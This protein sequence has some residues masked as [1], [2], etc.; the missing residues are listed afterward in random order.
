M[1]KVDSRN[2]AIGDEQNMLYVKNALARRIS[3]FKRPE[4]RAKLAK[5]SIVCKNFSEQTVRAC[6]GERKT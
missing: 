3:I 1:E 2:T 6:W 5:E 4:G